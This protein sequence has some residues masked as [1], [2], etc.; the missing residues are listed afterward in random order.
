MSQRE[1]IFIIFA[2]TC[3]KLA[4]RG[5]L[6]VF[7]F[8]ILPP[9]AR[10]ISPPPVRIARLQFPLVVNLALLVMVSHS[11]LHVKFPFSVFWAFFFNSD[12]QTQQGKEIFFIHFSVLKAALSVLSLIG[13]AQKIVSPHTLNIKSKA[14]FFILVTLQQPTHKKFPTSKMFP[15]ILA[16]QN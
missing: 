13:I 8:Q 4:T 2:R 7:C 1:R 14:N 9:P 12:R 10:H 5:N 6:S 11:R 3:S 16:L 15:V